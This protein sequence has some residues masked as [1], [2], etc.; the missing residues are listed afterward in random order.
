MFI[1]EQNKIKMNM[2]QGMLSKDE[3]NLLY[4]VLK[5]PNAK[6]RDMA[7]AINLSLG[8]TNSVYTLLKKEKYISEDDGKVTD[9]GIAALRPYK[10][11]NAIILAAGFASRCAPLSYERPKGLFTIKGEILIERQ[12]KQLIEKG[13]K[14][15]YVVVGY[16]KE[17]F[18]Y[19]EQ[20]YG[21][22]IIVN[23]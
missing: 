3:F 16:K 23:S 21:V 13:I 4:Y 11:E 10:V 7:E 15:I 17:L 8:K 18:F 14:K 2:G 12:I 19:L 9:N 1:F 5:N 6:Q 22:H 20:E